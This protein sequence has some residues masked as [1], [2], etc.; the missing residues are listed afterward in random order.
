[1]RNSG[2]KW[3]YFFFDPDAAM[4]GSNYDQIADH[5]NMPESLQ[6]YPEFST[7]IFSALI[8]NYDFRK[9]FMHHSSI[10]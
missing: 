4:S 8:R 9:R 5:N 7:E 2:S 3:R 10:I 1:L 6:V